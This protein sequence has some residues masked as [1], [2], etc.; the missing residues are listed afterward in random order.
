M[1]VKSIKNPPQGWHASFHKCFVL[2]TM[3]IKLYSVISLLFLQMIVTRSCPPRY[4]P[5]AGQEGGDHLSLL[6]GGGAQGQP[7]QQDVP[8]AEG[9]ADS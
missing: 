4:G 3:K 2:A 7:L 9:P 6:R 5:Q 1:H 8:G